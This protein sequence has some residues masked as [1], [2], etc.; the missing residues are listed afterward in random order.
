MAYLLLLVIFWKP[1]YNLFMWAVKKDTTYKTTF[2]D[3]FSHLW[4][5]ISPES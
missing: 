1:L 2:L 5:L 3:W 4:A